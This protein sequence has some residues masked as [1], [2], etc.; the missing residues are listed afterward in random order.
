MQSS[1]RSVKHLRAVED[2]V[3]RASGA[4]VVPIVDP[5]DDVSLETRVSKLKE[6]VFHLRDAFVEVKDAFSGIARAELR[7]FTRRRVRATHPR[8]RP[9]FERN[10]R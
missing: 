3:R 6:A 2:Y 8:R 5:T 7:A 1:P 9:P 4:D 10:D